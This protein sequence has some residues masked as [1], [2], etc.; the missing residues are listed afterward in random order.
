MLAKIHDVFHVSMLKKYHPN[1][2]HILQ[3]EDIEMGESLSHEKHAIELLDQKV[4]GLRNMQI[5]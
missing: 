4:K 5:S 2:T 1:S 3:F